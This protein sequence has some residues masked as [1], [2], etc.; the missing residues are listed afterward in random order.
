MKRVTTLIPALCLVALQ[1]TVLAQESTDEL[2]VIDLRPK[3]ETEGNGL[4]PLEGKCNKGVFRIAD[5]ASDPLKFDV[6]KE[7]LV[8]LFRMTGERKTLTVLNWSIYYNTQGGKGGGSGVQSVGVQGYAIPTGKTKEKQR[9]SKC[10]R[11]ESGGGWYDAGDVTSRYPPLVSELAGTFA[12]KP[13]NVRVVH[14]PRREI[15]GKFA[16][17]EDDTRELLATV[18]ETAE[19]VAAAIGR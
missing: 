14:S 9:A 19:A 2:I 8:P 15:A 13:F 18:H 6:L 7:D 4:A 3:E 10:S 12:G 17:G 11:A 16:G 1:Q 5:V